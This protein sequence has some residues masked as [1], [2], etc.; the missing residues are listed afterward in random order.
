MTICGEASRLSEEMWIN[1]GQ[2]CALFPPAP[3]TS[4]GKK[5]NPTTQK[6]C[7]KSVLHSLNKDAAVVC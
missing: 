2:S 7:Q 1:C 5:K 6:L 4:L 3:V